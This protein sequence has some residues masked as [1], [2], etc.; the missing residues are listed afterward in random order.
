MLRVKAL[1]GFLTAFAA[2]VE[3]PV[4]PRPAP[5]TVA[6][7]APPAKRP[8]SPPSPPPPPLAALRNAVADLGAIVGEPALF[9]GR[10]VVF[11]GTPRVT[12]AALLVSVATTPATLE[13]LGFPAA[14]KIVT[15]AQHGG[16]LYLLV[17]SVAWHDQ[18]A[19][20][21]TVVCP[22]PACE[23]ALHSDERAA[24]A[25]GP[26]EELATRIAMH[27]AVAEHHLSSPDA[28]ATQLRSGVASLLAPDVAFGRE[29]PP[30]FE[31]VPRPDAKTLA[32]LGSQVIA[33]Y[34][35]DCQSFDATDRLV[36]LR[37]VESAGPK[38]V[39]IGF[40]PPRSPPRE[41]V[42]P[43]A[44]DKV[45]D[46]GTIARAIRL[47][48]IESATVLGAAPLGSNGMVGVIT[49]GAARYKVVLVEDDVIGSADL[50]AYFNEEGV[51]V[52]FA[53]IDGDGRTDF[54][55]SGVAGPP[56]ARAARMFLTPQTGAELASVVDQDAVGYFAL[57]GAR[58]LE[59]GRARVLALPTGG[60]T[61]AEACPLVKALENR[62]SAARVL[63][64]HAT[65]LTYD[66][67]GWI[68]GSAKPASV[69]KILR[70][71]PCEALECSSSRPTCAHVDGPLRDYF[72]F[73]RDGGALKV[74][75]VI[76]Y[77][78]S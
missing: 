15:T 72:L 59:D 20:L 57:R 42:K 41:R 60:V 10:W 35:D 30:F 74:A 61:R 23:P 69:G 11:V 78:G 49:T 64:P 7:T 32:Q 56:S 65:L 22:D 13:H 28:V 46:D 6:T 52:G 47:L 18:P 58:S 29:W 53:D 62:G 44:F 27:H 21:R 1:A 25:A 5:Q 31:S 54:V 34:S 71:T 3:P 37:V 40:T 14:A 67:P 26:P 48:G 63:T 17:E 24:I 66:E 75:G 2:C 12:Q 36:T 77:T 55:M 9:E 51:R 16:H 19:G 45:P 4:A 68:E 73:R 70:T 39:A 38:V 50:V 43:R 76:R 33:C 8:T